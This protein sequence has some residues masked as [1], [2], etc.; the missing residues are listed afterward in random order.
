MKL[1]GSKWLDQ[2][3]H[4]SNFQVG[5]SAQAWP[6]RTCYFYC[7]TPQRTINWEQKCPQRANLLM[8]WMLM[9][10]S[11]L[12]GISCDTFAR[13]MTLLLQIVSLFIGHWKLLHWYINHVL[14]QYYYL[15]NSDVIIP[16][17]YDA[18][19]LVRKWNNEA[20]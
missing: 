2:S 17:L 4:I 18:A 11:Q 12:I 7:T 13:N 8:C 9:N 6:Q 15:L 3:C 14:G 10:I 19:Q 16:Y 20:I 5:I 1:R